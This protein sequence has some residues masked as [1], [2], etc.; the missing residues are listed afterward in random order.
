[1]EMKTALLRIPAFVIDLVLVSGVIMLTNKIA[2]IAGLV[3]GFMPVEAFMLLALPLGFFV[4]WLTGLHLGKRLFGL[5]VIDAKTGQP[6][7]SFQWF[8]R[9]LL[10]SLVVSLNVFLFIPVLVSRE[11][12]GFHDM[13]AGTRV[14]FAGELTDK[15]KES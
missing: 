6:P 12:K 4:Y 3:T 9:C 5:K 13:I 11:Q 1:M 10:F 15:K 2:V 14:V 8:R 7:S